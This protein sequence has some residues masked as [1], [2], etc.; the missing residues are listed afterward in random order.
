[1]RLSS[2]GDLREEARLRRQV[3]ELQLAYAYLQE[4]FRAALADIAQRPAP[5]PLW[6]TTGTG[7]IGVGPSILWGTAGSQ[8]WK[9]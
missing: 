1:M 2:F 7:A 5:P 8:T 6:T 9:G 3:E 4:Q